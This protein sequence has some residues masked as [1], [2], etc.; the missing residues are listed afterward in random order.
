MIFS[1]VYF[2]KEEEEKS[3]WEKI[4]ADR[5]ERY[6]SKRKKKRG[7]EKVKDGNPAR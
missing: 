6:N 3:Y 4:N 1:F 7:T 2:F 5:I